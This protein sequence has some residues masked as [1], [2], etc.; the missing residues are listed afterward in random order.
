MLLRNVCEFQQM[1]R[2][3]LCSCFLKCTEFSKKIVRN[4]ENC[5]CCQVYLAIDSNQCLKRLKNK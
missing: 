4:L 5:A 2:S 1:F 3:N